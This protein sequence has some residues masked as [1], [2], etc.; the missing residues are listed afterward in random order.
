MSKTAL[1]VFVIQ[2][3]VFPRHEDEVPVEEGER[4]AGAYAGSTGLRR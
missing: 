4:E 2:L 1:V 3:W